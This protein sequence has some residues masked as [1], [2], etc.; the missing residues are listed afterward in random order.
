MDT[1]VKKRLGREKYILGKESKT[2]VEN[3][4]TST[5]EWMGQGKSER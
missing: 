1:A 5:G 4:E 3:G 2:V